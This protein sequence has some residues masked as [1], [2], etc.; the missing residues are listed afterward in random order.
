MCLPLESTAHAAGGSGLAYGRIGAFSLPAGLGEATR[1]STIHLN[2][3]TM[4]L[5]RQHPAPHA[6]GGNSA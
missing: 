6:Y 3:R 1:D 2:I 5:E 4:P